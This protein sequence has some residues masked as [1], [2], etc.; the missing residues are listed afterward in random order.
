MPVRNEL[1]YTRLTVRRIRLETR[2]L[3]SFGLLVVALVAGSLLLVHLHMASRV[4]TDVERRLDTSRRI[5]EELL[6]TRAQ[7]LI[8]EAAL[9]AE[10]PALRRAA[11][12]W[13]DDDLSAAF[14]EINR[15]IGSVVVILTDRMGVILARSDRRWEPGETFEQA[16]SVARALQGQRA[17]SMWVAEDRLYQM[18]SVPLRLP[19]GLAGTLS[20]GFGVGGELARE[21]ARLSGNDIAF[22]VGSEVIAA[23]R[24]LADAER[25]ELEALATMLGAFDPVASSVDLSRDVPAMVLSPFIGPGAAAVGAFGILCPVADAA[26]E[27]GALERSLVM[28]AFLALAAVLVVGFALSH[29]ITR[30]LRTLSTAAVELSAGNY[31]FPLPP[32]SGSVEV[33]DLTLA[34]ESMRRALRERIDELRELAARLEEKVG[35]RTAELEGALGENRKLLAELRR[36]GDELER[37]VEERTRDLASA[38]QMLIR[39]DRM[40]AVGRLAAGI[41]HEV[42]NPLGVV[43]GFAEGL[44]DRARDPDLAVHPGFREFPEHLRLIV[45]EVE[46]LKDIVQKFLS[47]ARSRAP[48]KEPVNLNSVASHVLELLTAQARREGKRLL[49][50]LG[51]EPLWIEADPEQLKQVLLNL[52]LN[53]LDAVARGGTVRVRT[54]SNGAVAELYVDDDGHGIPAEIRSRIFEPFFSTKP[55]ERGTGLGLSLCADLVRENGGEIQLVGADSASPET[56]NA[57]THDD[58]RETVVVPRSSDA[59]ARVMQGTTFVVRFARLESQ[60]VLAQA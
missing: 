53:G 14:R 13:S 18:V 1:A 29:S 55:P 45:R 10:L 44:L 21:V 48:R 50:A 4:R 9:V 30:P 22:L 43:S 20:V 49:G 8:K 35:E 56:Q 59:G 17:S 3:G 25:T 28:G 40:A 16:T 47:F 23:S 36:W 38:Q 57:S 42:N 39:Q 34:F 5:V 7:A 12:T 11:L 19:T 60:H 52:A 15:L 32:P 46:R 27:L 54:G 31:D 37:K 2:V 24:S 33:E 6:D 58:V 26:A 41:A 51:A